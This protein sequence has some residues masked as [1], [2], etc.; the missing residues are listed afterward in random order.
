MAL[1]KT[2]YNIFFR[3]TSTFFVTVLVG[4]VFFERAFEASTDTLWDRMNKGVR[5]KNKSFL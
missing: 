4:A 3:R 5:N 1:S 2:I